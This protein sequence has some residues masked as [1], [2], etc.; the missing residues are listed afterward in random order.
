MEIIL[1]VEPF[2]EVS[3]QLPQGLFQSTFKTNYQRT[4]EV[5]FGKEK[6]M[7]SLVLGRGNE[8]PFWNKPRQTRFSGHRHFRSISFRLHSTE[9]SGAEAKLFR[10]TAS[11]S[12]P[13]NKCPS[14]SHKAEKTVG[15][16]KAK[17][18]YAYVNFKGLASGIR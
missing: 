9:N 8:C 5:G 10:S 13:K 16:R 2:I 18:I 7:E 4:K 12:N 11:N 17:P 15:S 3:G 6:W 14:T 1:S